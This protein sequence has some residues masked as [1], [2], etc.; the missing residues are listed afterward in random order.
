MNQQCTQTRVLKL[1]IEQNKLYLEELL[2]FNRK[3]SG[4]GLSRTTIYHDANLVSWISNS[5]GCKLCKC[6]KISS[7]IHNL[8]NLLERSFETNLIYH[9]PNCDLNLY[10]FKHIAFRNCRVL[11]TAIIL[12]VELP[13]SKHRTCNLICSAFDFLPYYCL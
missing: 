11:Y 12:I 8:P 5:E 4:I 13:N 6:A 10:T 9:I 1:E 3:Q 7:F 2:V